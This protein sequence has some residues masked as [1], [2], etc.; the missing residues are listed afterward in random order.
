[1]LLTI[2]I[3]KSLHLWLKCRGKSERRF[4]V[5]MYFTPTMFLLCFTYQ[6]AGVQGYSWK[7]N[8][9]VNVYHLHAPEHKHIVG[10]SDQ[11]ETQW[12]KHTLTTP[13]F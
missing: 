4:I 5:L 2:F 8:L 6:I 12:N 7:K 1:M 3:L 11:G 9:K 13:L 10:W